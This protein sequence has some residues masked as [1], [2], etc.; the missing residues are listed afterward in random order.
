MF[1]FHSDLLQLMLE[2]PQQVLSGARNAELDFV[3][4][5]INDFT[6]DKQ[7]P[8]I[9]QINSEAELEE[10]YSYATFLANQQEIAEL[11][12]QLQA[13]PYEKVTAFL[14]ELF[15]HVT[16]TVDIYLLPIGFPRGDA[17]VRNL[18]GE[19][20]ICLNLAAILK[21]GQD[22]AERVKTVTPVLEHE[23]FHI[24]FERRY[25]DT[26]YWV[27]FEEDLTAAKEARFLVLNEGIAHFIADWE[28]IDQFLA[29][30]R[31]QLHTAVR[32]YHEVMQQLDAGNLPMDDARRLIMWGI[33]GPFFEKYLA[34]AG[35]LA[36]YII[37]NEHGIVG[38]KRCLAD[39]DFFYQHGLA[40]LDSLFL[41]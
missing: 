21:Y 33:V 3:E 1:K 35:M 30:R 32:R 15:D 8:P 23:M 18:N 26:P 5:T 39:L 22:T 34:M 25:K 31:E 37:L 36:A 16:E 6:L 29:N 24:F 20:V 28:R 13:L 9:A 12:A 4:D 14:A 19:T 11:G 2:N 41:G 27:E 38:L 10:Y 17:Y 40:K 7:I